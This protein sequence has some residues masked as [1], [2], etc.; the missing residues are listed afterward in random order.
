MAAADPLGGQKYW[1]D[2]QPF[3][4]VRNSIAETGGLKFWADG[5]PV[6]FL[7][8]PGFVLVY[9]QPDADNSDGNW[10]NELDSTT[11]LY[12]SIDETSFS[13]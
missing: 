11:D 8:P 12:A 3:I 13:D 7:L 5:L 4:G 10:T 1:V 6:A 9:M 2:G